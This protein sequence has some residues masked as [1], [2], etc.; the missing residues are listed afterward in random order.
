MLTYVF[1]AVRRNV[2]HCADD[3][4]TA[5]YLEMD[6][7]RVSWFLSID[8]ADLP[9]GSQGSHRAV[10]VDGDSFEFSS[11]FTD[12]HTRSYEEIVAGRGFGIE[13]VR[14]SIEIVAALR[15]AAC[16]PRAGHLHPAARRHAR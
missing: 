7:A 8:P 14:P 5:G 13:T 10:M 12:L 2:L 3:R 6:R 1:G 4:R 16:E 9:P 15:H 11:G